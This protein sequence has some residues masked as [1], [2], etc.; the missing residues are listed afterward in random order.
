MPRIPLVNGL[1]FRLFALTVLFG[2]VLTALGG[3]ALWAQWGN[4]RAARID[5]L[6]L[7]DEVAV[8]VIET[9]RA[10]SEA[11]SLTVE[12][13]RSRAFA[14]LTAMSYGNGDY[15]SAI[16][17]TTGK[18]LAHP[19]PKQVGADG[20]A[21]KDPSGFFFVADVIPR[22]VHDGVATVEYSYPRI[23]Q[24]VPTP[25]ISVY[26]YYAPWKLVIGTGTYVDDLRAD[27]YNSALW[28]GIVGLGS[29]V[30]ILT[31]GAF[32]ARSITR[33]TASVAEAMR[34]IASGDTAVDVPDG[35]TITET[36]AMAAAV[37]VFKD[38]AVEK[39]LA[40]EA[41]EVARREADDARTRQEE[42][43]TQSAAQQVVVVE[44][45]AAGMD[46]LSAGDLTVRLNEAFAPEYERLRGDFNRTVEQL[47]KTVGAVVESAS[48]I[49]TGTG[50]I[51]SAADDLSRRTEQQAAS[52]EQT[53]AALEEIT[54]TVRKT[55]E[56][57][58]HAREIAAASQAGTLR[59]SQVVQ[60]AVAAMTTIEKSAKE[61]SQIIG[62]IDEIAFQTNLLALNAGVEA[63]RAGD[64]GRGFAVVAS[65]VRAL[66]QRSAQAAK[67]IK[68]LISASTQQVGR[69]VELVGE[70]GRSLVKIIA[71]VGQINGVVG[72]IAASAQ[73]QAS[74]LHEVSAAVNQMDQ[75][76][77]QNAAMVEQST[78]ASHGLA[79]EISELDRLTSHFQTGAQ[80]IAEAA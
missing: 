15:F 58:G 18:I 43:A 30:I 47:A 5:E 52:L 34:R 39:A 37:Q 72:E 3:F 40:N 10:L 38:T 63:A 14:Q 65:E 70:T 29:L 35:G 24:T 68:A 7:L 23:G 8:K 76:T 53:A 32:T 54:A 56:A 62:V 64:A 78:A 12:A 26:H 69:G 27:Y 33:P 6:R 41:A 20:L 50:E 44:A 51:T 55:A 22:A 74:G 17:V 79:Q 13:A 57:A 80:L 2:A 48:A 28:M 25:K 59:S 31:V 66:A 71:E 77:Q 49:R 36:R 21:S 73:E 46:R 1:S 67:E 45:L 9:N 60:D 4:A 61:I 42:L 11:G 19:N 16:D 75:I